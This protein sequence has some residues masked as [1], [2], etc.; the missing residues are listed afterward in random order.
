MRQ[1]WFI[2]LHSSERERK[3]SRY[4][5]VVVERRKVG[6]RQS[7]GKCMM[8]DDDDLVELVVGRT[9]CPNGHALLEQLSWRFFNCLVSNLV[10]E[11]AAD[12]NRGQ[13]E[14]RAI[15]KTDFAVQE[16]PYR[17]Y[18]RVNGFWKK[19]TILY[20]KLFKF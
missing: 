6:N 2:T 15:L 14:R 8:A 1:I 10:I 7:K 18:F 4:V 13:K 19:L 16:K 11:M 20:N 5:R 17:S 3:F 12:V 9:E